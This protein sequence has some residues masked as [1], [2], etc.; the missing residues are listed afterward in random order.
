MRIAY[1]IDDLHRTGGAQR[2]TVRL[3]EQAASV[4]HSVDLFAL[5]SSDGGGYTDR[6]AAAGARVEYFP[7]PSLLSVR[8]LVR[9][10]R[11]PLQSL[12]R[13]DRAAPG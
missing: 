2:A 13:P 11:A 12:D 1:V 3:V 4:P 9:L 8:R 10:T 7:A 5:A 6:L